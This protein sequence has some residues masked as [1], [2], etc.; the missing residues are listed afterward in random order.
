M[1]QLQ[2]ERSLD[3]LHWFP[4]LFTTLP[5]NSITNVSRILFFLQLN[6][7]RAKLYTEQGITTGWANN[8]SFFGIQPFSLKNKFQKNVLFHED[9]L[10]PTYKCMLIWTNSCFV[11]KLNKSAFKIQ[12]QW[13]ISS[14]P[15]YLP[16]PCLFR[17]SEYSLVCVKL[18][19]EKSVPKLLLA[20]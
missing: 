16:F 18:T 9:S 17:I 7:V 11:N 20:K 15:H 3:R 12:P 2:K 13:N 19:G 1:C 5:T 10:P 6:Q 4:C 8:T 14:R